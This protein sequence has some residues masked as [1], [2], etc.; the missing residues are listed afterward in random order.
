MK[1]TI[2]L[3]FISAFLALG[4]VVL[5][6]FTNIYTFF[7]LTD[8]VPIAELTFVETGPEQYLA[9]IS[10]GDFCEAEQYTLYGNQWR[11]DARFLK[12]QSWANLFGLDAMYRIERLGGRYRDVGDENSSQQVA[13]TLY[14]APRIDL[15]AILKDYDGVFSPVDTLFGSSVYEDMDADF[16]YRVFRS[17]SGLLVRKEPLTAGDIITIEINS[18]CTPRSG[19]FSK[20]AGFTGKLFQA[21]GN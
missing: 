14:A 8:E 20:F 15:A 12:W 17:Q 18:N 9:T 11:L 2:V 16:R 3:P 7:R 4:L 6:V 21:D 13:Y 5:L 1:R 10:Y 19:L